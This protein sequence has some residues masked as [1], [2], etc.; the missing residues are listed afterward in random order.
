[1]TERRMHDRPGPQ[2]P[3]TTAD[4]EN[5]MTPWERLFAGW[6]EALST[7]ETRRMQRHIERLQAAMGPR[8][9]P[10]P[11]RPHERTSDEPA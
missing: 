4:R 7:Q 3:D 6:Q 2:G 11:H 10:I 9:T 5:P 1:M 8:S